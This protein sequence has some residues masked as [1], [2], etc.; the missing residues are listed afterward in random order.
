MVGGDEDVGVLI[1]PQ[2]GQRIA[3]ALQ[4]FL[5]SSTTVLQS[6]DVD[7]EMQPYL[8]WLAANVDVELIPVPPP[9]AQSQGLRSENTR[10]G[11]ISTPPHRRPAPGC[12]RLTAGDR[13]GNHN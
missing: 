1:E 2:R 7:P 5:S 12:R 3:Q 6:P 10:S 9:A 4:V 13:S 11:I 8:Q